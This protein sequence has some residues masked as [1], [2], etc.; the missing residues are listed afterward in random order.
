MA[1]SRGV[2]GAR[3]QRA[4]NGL[5]SYLPTS[6]RASWAGRFLFAGIAFLG[7]AVILY[8]GNFF[9][10]LLWL[11]G[12]VCVSFGAVLFVIKDKEVL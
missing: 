1:G 2:G 12:S 4:D 10:P 11:L 8:H 3:G 6:R 5:S 7:S 9:A